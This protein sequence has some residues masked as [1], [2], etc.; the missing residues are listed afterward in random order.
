MIKAVIFDMYETLITLY[1]SPL[2]F[3]AQIAEDAGIPVEKFQAMWRPTEKGRTIGVYTF[4]GLIERFLKECGC[5]TDEKH[6]MIVK[7]RF[8]CKKEAFDHMNDEIIPMLEALR[9]QNIKIGLI[10]NCFDEEAIA[11]RQSVLWNYFDVACLSYEEGV[12]KPNQE[13]FRRCLDKLQLNAD[14]CLYV[15]DGGS[16]ELEAATEAGMYAVQAAWYLKDG[17]MQ[18]ATRKKEFKQLDR[19]YDVIDLVVAM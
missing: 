18:P 17:T 3:G 7:K 15:G 5:Y 19:P 16:N 6:Q 11:I 13:I 4:E 9:K 10:S 1:E 14:E 2:Y 8:D 12:Q